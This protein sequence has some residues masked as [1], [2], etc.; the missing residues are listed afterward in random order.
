MRRRELLSL[1]G[2]AAIGAPNAA[3]AQPAGNPIRIGFLGPSLDGAAPLAHYK[4][5]L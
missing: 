5:R 2:G 4:A 1:L 3:R